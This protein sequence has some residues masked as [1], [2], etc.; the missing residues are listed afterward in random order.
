MNRETCGD[1]PQE[2]QLEF[3]KAGDEICARK[4]NLA[5]R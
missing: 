1:L 3:E 2:L 5:Q 4:A